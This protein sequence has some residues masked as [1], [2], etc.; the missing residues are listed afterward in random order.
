VEVARARL[1][2]LAPEGFEEREA[3]DEVEL[4]VYTDARGEERFRDVFPVADTI[5]VEPGW[6]E[7]WRE[8]HAAVR[9]AGVWV[10]PPWETPP[11]EVPAVVVE[12][13]RAFGTGAH[14]T[15]RACIALLA[16][17]ER[18]S[19]LDAGCGSGVLALVAARLGFGPILAVDI[20]EASVEA[21]RANASRNGID[22]DVR[23]LDVLRDDLPTAD[24]VIANIELSLV[25][26]LLRRWAGRTAVTS[27]YL[28]RERPE[29]EGWS[30]EER[31]ELEG[32]AADRLV[33][34]TTV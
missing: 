18:G 4:A 20:D 6:E 33:S 17:A 14:P 15:T 34:R 32:W 22:L 27:G 26:E 8:F 28:V 7:R 19:L 24:L 25:V 11:T 9:V 5:A 31:L 13:G 2:V 21:T 23:L 10:G 12:P 1:V 3:G 30:S 29:V 16:R